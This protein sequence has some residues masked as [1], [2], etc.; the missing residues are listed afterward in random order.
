[1]PGFGEVNFK[2]PLILLFQYLLMLNFHAQLVEHSFTT[3]VLELMII[4]DV[5]QEN[6]FSGFLTRSNTNQTAS[7]K[8]EIFGNR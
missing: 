4:R 6:W 3:L 8:L 5:V 1:M 2:D 7:Y